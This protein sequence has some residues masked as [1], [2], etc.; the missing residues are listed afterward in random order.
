LTYLCV[1]GDCMHRPSRALL[2][3]PVVAAVAGGPFGGDDSG[4]VPPDRSVAKCEQQVATSL[5][6]FD[7][8]V[9][10]CNVRAVKAAFKGRPHLPACTQT[11]ARSCR[12]KYD[13]ASARTARTGRCPACLSPPAQGLLADRAAARLAQTA[14]AIHCRAAP[15]AAALRCEA[16]VARNLA[17]TIVCIANC[18]VAA[19]S[20]GLSSRAFDEEGCERSCRRSCDDASARL[21][22]RCP[23]CL[24]GAEQAD[25]ADEVQA[26]ADEEN[27]DIFCAGGSATTTTTST[28]LAASTTSTMVGASTTSIAP[29]TSTTSTT[30]AAS[31]TSVAPTTSTTSTTLACTGEGALCGP[32]LDGCTARMVCVDG[33]LVC[34][35]TF[36]A[37]PPRGDPANPGT[38]SAPLSSIAAGIENAALLGVAAVCA[39][40]GLYFEDLTIVEGISLRGG[41]DCT[42]WTRDPT[43]NFTGVTGLPPDGVKVP[44]GVTAATSVDGLLVAGIAGLA[45]VSSALTVTDASPTLENLTVTNRVIGTSQTPP[46][47]YALR[48]RQ[49]GV[50]PASPTIDGG[51]YRAVSPAGG[52]GIGIFIEGASPSLTHVVVYGAGADVYSPTPATAAGIRCVGCAGTTISQSGIV[53]G[54]ATAM[55]VGLWA[56]GDVSGLS[57]DQ[58]FFWGG[59][60]GVSAVLSYGTL[61]DDCTG[62]STWSVLSAGYFF[63]S[64]APTTGIGF[65]ASG[66]SCAPSLTA[67]RLIGCHDCTDSAALQCSGAPCTVTDSMLNATFDV[68]VSAGTSYGAR[69]LDGGCALLAR[70]TITTGDVFDYHLMPGEGIGVDVEGASPAL[71]ANVIDG[72]SCPHGTSSSSTT[73]RLRDSASMVTNNL[74][75]GGSCDGAS[76]VVRFEKGSGPEALSPTIENNT[77]EYGGGTHTGL[78]VDSTGSVP[79]AGY[80]RNNIIQNTGSGGSTFAV[81]EADASSDLAALENNDLDDPTG[82]LYYDEGTTALTLSDINALPGAAGN[83]SADPLLDATGHLAAAS[84]CRNAGTATGAPATDRDGDS[85][86]QEGAFDI[87]A[88]EFVP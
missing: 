35:G 52:T 13:R 63:R 47:L 24:G 62:T 86:P 64:P 20:A 55:S 81:Y 88:D 23:P 29:T 83:I 15:D 77:L 58:A 3:L 56:S 8:C 17:R 9:V 70:N 66:A 74:L 2:F 75:R 53:G 30:F 80:V 28:T 33:A 12:G 78:F 26:A 34:R 48:I 85:R 18:H 4:F 25:L 72:A 73:L 19:A 21:A 14:G 84:P 37:P 36:V 5:A 16:A 61:L 46:T 22:P 41:Y 39:C 82:V 40:A 6:S 50:S 76:E 60:A 67:S 1:P 11:G 45:D 54:P 10:T 31:T 38:E 42:T 71:D 7:R 51:E 68:P 43:T 87:G 32:T 59:S 65:A 27:G 57:A 44:P 69:C 79:P 49:T